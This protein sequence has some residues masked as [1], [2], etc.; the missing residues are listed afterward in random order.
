MQRVDG[1]GGK[2]CRIA[3]LELA[4]L[5]DD[6][7]LMDRRHD[8]LGARLP[9]VDLDPSFPDPPPDRAVVT[10]DFLGDRAVP[11][12]EW[13]L[14]GGL[15][16]LKPYLVADEVDGEPG[17]WVLLDGHVDQEDLTAH[18]GRFVFPRGLLVP[19]R[20]VDEVV[21]HLERQDLGNR[22]L[23]ELPKDRYRFAGEIPWC[24]TYPA[25]G[26]SDLDF[27]VDTQT[28]METEQRLM[29]TRGGA[30][31]PAEDEEYTGLLARWRESRIAGEREGDADP[32]GIQVTSLEV[33]VARERPVYRTFQVLLPVREDGWEDHHS[34]VNPGRVTA[35][36]ARE[37][38]DRLGLVGQPQTFDLF[39][40]DGR[41]ASIAGESGDPWHTH[42]TLTYLRRD[43]LDRYLEDTGQELVWAIWGE[44]EVAAKSRSDHRPEAQ[45]AT[46][47]RVFQEIRR[48][49]RPT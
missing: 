26:P 11:L 43:L 18:R 42:Q 10:A 48:Y 13:I 44:R 4:G 21:A 25:N 24:E 2:Y 41:R 32:D 12:Q 27:E 9:F 20:D 3:M 19:S 47:Y 36:P 28:V 7:G 49:V 16:D 39:E 14:D 15:P 35:A 31:V 22:W 1:Y 23:P 46:P 37:I 6:E 45:I 30:V 29:V 38:A 17:P 5:R 34:V 33:E 8:L 40:R